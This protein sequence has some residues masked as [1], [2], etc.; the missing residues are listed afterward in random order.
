LPLLR[1]IIKIEM[2]EILVIDLTGQEVGR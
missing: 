1:N 2:A